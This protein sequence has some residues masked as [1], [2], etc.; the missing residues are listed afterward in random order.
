MEKRYN[1]LTVF[2]KAKQG[3]YAKDMVRARCSCGYV[4][5]ASL[6]VIKSG[7]IKECTLC[8]QRR[9]HD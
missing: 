4:I 5:T 1:N 8:R 6:S 2:K 9:N 3:V 7:V